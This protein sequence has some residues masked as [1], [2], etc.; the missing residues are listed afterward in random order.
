L[1][2]HKLKHEITSVL[3]SGRT[4]YGGSQKLS[5]NKIF[6]SS[7][8]GLV[9]ACDLF[10][11]MH[12]HLEGCSS[13]LFAHLPSSGTVD[14]E[15]YNNLLNSL[16]YYFPLIPNY[17]INGLMLTLGINSFFIRHS[18]P[19]IAVWGIRTDKLWER[20]EKMLSQDIPVIISVGPNLSLSPDKYK[21]KMYS[22]DRNGEL[23]ESVKV[24]AHYMTVT[25]IDDQW[26]TVSS[27]GRKYFISRSD[28]RIYVKHHSAS[29][30]SNIVYITR[31]NK[32]GVG[33]K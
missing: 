28:Y 4:T 25:A 13:N 32:I 19:Y 2:E 12:R 21:A 27:W 1:G 5:K 15:E 10:M 26:L 16:S 9:A 17:G 20:I 23:R 7:G 33:M 3:K 30:F 29:L 8:C 6:Q 18:F 24:S 22:A 11:Y 14:I 31:N